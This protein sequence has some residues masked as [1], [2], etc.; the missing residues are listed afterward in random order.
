MQIALR[1]SGVV[2]LRS[3]KK[4]LTGASSRNFSQWGVGSRATSLIDL[5]DDLDK[6]PRSKVNSVLNVC[7]Q[8]ERMVV[9]RLGKLNQIH[10]S[11]WFIAIPFVDEIRFVIDMREKALSISPQSAITKDNVHVL[12]SGNLSCQFVDPEK[13]AYGS[14]NPIYAVRQHAQS[15]MRAAIG[16]LE[17]DQILRA[18][19]EL[20]AVIRKAVQEAADAW[21]LEIKRYEITEVTPDRTI[22][23]AMGRQAASERERRSKVLEAEGNKKSAELESEGVKIR[24]KNESEGFVIEAENKA[25]AKKLQL[26]L[27]AEGEACVIEIKAKAQAQAIALLSESLKA[28]GPLGADAARLAVA[29]DMISMYADIG[30]KSNTMFFSERPADVTSLLAQAA[31]VLSSGGG[32]GGGVGGGHKGTNIFIPGGASSNSDASGSSRP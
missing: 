31:A 8:G 9:E 15:S 23:E 6:W 24:M 28:A 2:G 16:E 19:S 21:G 14:K 10:E 12:V 22:Q 4:S 27:E 32:S 1:R 3:G 26:Q 13:A 7:A 11:G 18:R 17:L 29:R 20:N 25:R 5:D 30:S